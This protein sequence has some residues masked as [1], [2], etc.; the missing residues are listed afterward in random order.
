[1][2]FQPVPTTG[3]MEHNL[4]EGSQHWSWVSNIVNLLKLCSLGENRYEMFRLE[5]RIS[6]VRWWYFK[7]GLLTKMCKEIP[8]VVNAFGMLTKED[9]SH[10][11]PTERPLERNSDFAIYNINSEGWFQCWSMLAGAAMA[12]FWFYIANYYLFVVSSGPDDEDNLR[13]KDCKSGQIW[14]RTF[15]HFTFMYHG[16]HFGSLSREIKFYT[17]HPDDGKLNAKASYNYKN[18][19]AP[20]REYKGWGKMRDMRLM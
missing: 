7:Q 9:T 13:L 3:R 10:G 4:L 6:Y 19:Y 1:M 12:T 18:P 15:W 17:H 20:D 8:D 5:K 11:F 16:Q 2:H 14:E